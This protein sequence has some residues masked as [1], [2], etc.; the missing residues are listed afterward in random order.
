MNLGKVRIKNGT[1]YYF[2]DVVKLENFDLDVLIDEKSHEKILIFATSCKTLLIQNLCELDSIK[3][4]DLQELM[5]KI[6][7]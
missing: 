7:I 3:Q 5:M 6:D 4:M 2:D 1:C